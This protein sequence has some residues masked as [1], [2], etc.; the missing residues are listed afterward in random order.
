M[1][2]LTLHHILGL[3][4]TQQEIADILG[5]QRE[6]YTCACSKRNVSYNDY[7]IRM[8]AR[9]MADTKGKKKYEHIRSAIEH[10]K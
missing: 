6:T 10:F 4:Y 8:K 2:Q 5:V 7:M 1:K 9:A 3:L